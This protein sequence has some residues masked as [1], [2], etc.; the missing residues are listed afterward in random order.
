M[1]IPAVYTNLFWLIEYQLYWNIQYNI[2][3]YNIII[4]SHLSLFFFSEQIQLDSNDVY[5]KDEPLF[6]SSD[7]EKVGLESLFW[8]GIYLFILFPHLFKVSLKIIWSVFSFIKTYYIFELTISQFREL[9]KLY[10]IVF[11]M[12]YFNKN[13]FNKRRLFK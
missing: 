1:S 6:P 8:W 7:H 2:I 13:Y 5:I 9:D 12:Y 4:V 10:F 3:I 11:H